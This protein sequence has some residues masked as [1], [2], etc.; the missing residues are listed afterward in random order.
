MFRPGGFFSVLREDVRTIV[1]RDP[2]VRN[3]FEAFT[4]PALPALWTHR[5]AHPLYR[6]GLR[7]IARALARSARS[8]TGVEIH[9]GAHLGRRVLIDHGAAVV[10]GETATV[11]D[12]VTIYHQVT[13]GAV[14]WWRDCARPDG[15]RR[16]PVVHNG[17]ILGANSTVLGPITIGEG[18]VVGAQ[19]LVV[20]DIPARW[21]VLAPVGEGKSIDTSFGPQQTPC[22]EIAA[23]S[24][25]SGD[26]SGDA[27]I[28]RSAHPSP[29]QPPSHPYRTDLPPEAEANHKD[30]PHLVHMAATSDASR[31]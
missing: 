15:E 4:H 24:A 12:D 20:T 16:H 30:A 25:Q 1:Q 17:V 5:I 18:A 21:R 31:S 9:P 27:E 13:L 19:A 7:L 3:I 11:G 29:E 14:G 2:S 26:H 23:G 22:T 28:Y 8:Q 6:C 10:I